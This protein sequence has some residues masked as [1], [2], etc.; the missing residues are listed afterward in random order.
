[1]RALQATA[2]GGPEV[3]MW[4][5][6]P[7]PTP[8]PGEIKMR[9]LANAV[10]WSDVL[11]REGR[12]PGGPT[13][14]FVVGHDIVA[15]VVELGD[16]VD[17]FTIGERVYG[18]LVDAGGVA[19][20]AVAPASWMHR[21]P[22]SLSAVDAAAAPSPFFTA[23]AAITTMAQLTRGQTVLVHAAAGGFGSAAVQLCRA[24]GA[25]LV[26]A[27]A[28]GPEKMEPVRSFGADVAIDY[29]HEDFVEIVRQATEGRG[30]DLVVDSV[31]GDVLAASFDAV[32]P[33]GKIICVGATAGRSTP[34]FRLHTL[35]EKDIW[36]G[37]FTLGNW[38]RHHPEL[39]EPI[40]A[41]VYDLLET[42][43]LRVIVS[44]VFSP[45]EARQAHVHL[46]NRRSIG[47]TVIDF[48]AP[49]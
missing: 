43:V 6:V 12:Y 40:A 46:Q 39:I 23:E 29:L 5:E 1:M 48:S 22:P 44:R 45:L 36:V 10:N 41:T 8:A 34:R 32:A 4:A 13:P 18:C 28:G 31:G 21:A 38:I 17:R 2:V 16:G 14:P 47:R 24:H 19:E 3:L 26:L 20:Y 35:F 33:A 9:V 27:T 42:A 37:G 7:E 15:D 49:A 30:V 25:G 11:E